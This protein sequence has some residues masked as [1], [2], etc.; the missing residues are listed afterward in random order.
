MP[1]AEDAES[2]QKVTPMMPSAVSSL[3]ADLDSVHRGS[4]GHGCSPQ[5]RFTG[6]SDDR[7]AGRYRPMRAMSISISIRPALVRHRR[8]GLCLAVL[9]FSLVPLVLGESG[10][11]E[12]RPTAVP[13]SKPSLDSP[14][15][16][17]PSAPSTAPSECRS[18]TLPRFSPRLA[19]STGSARRSTRPTG[20]SPR[21]PDP[22]SSGSGTRAGSKAG[23]S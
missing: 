12:E 16:W 22:R 8:T 5:G 14:G 17:Q 21:R 23:S 20:R 9:A 19:C 6:P 15:T 18:A 11:L 1:G 3:G 7:A 4:I 2:L 10:E 13:D